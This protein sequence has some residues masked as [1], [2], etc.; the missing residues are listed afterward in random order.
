[1]RELNETELVRLQNLAEDLKRQ[2]IKSQG[3]HSQ[4]SSIPFFFLLQ[5]LAED[6][7]RLLIKSQGACFQTS[8]QQ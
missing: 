1:V 4:K 7:K 8:S 2:L 6:L 5:N 3:T